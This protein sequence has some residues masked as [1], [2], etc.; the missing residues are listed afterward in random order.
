MGVPRAACK[1]QRELGNGLIGERRVI[2]QWLS[3]RDQQM[4]ILIKLTIIF[5]FS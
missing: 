3:Q 1:L 5:S 2:I 4:F